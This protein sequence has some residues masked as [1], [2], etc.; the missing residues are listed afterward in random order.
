MRIKITSG[1]ASAIAGTFLLLAGTPSTTMAAGGYEGLESSGI[2]VHDLASVQRGAGLFFNYCH[3]CHSA[4]YMRYQRLAQDLELPEEMVQNNLV[5]G[6]RE[7]TDYMKAAIPAENATSWFGKKPPDLTLK[8]RSRGPDWIYT[9][10][11][12]YYMTDEG[13]NN[14]ILENASMPNVLWELQGIQRPIFETH[15]DETGATHSELVEL[16]LDQPGLQSPEEFERTVRD[17]TAFMEYLAEPAVLKRERMGIWVLLF[18]VAFTFMSWLL[19][20]E[21]WK[22]VKK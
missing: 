13:W 8:A 10:L 7:I 19:Y 21:Y 18:M 16:R 9:F 14:K 5:F 3:S 2:N 15:T 17:I 1:I 20:H 22:D 11:K 6:D 4:E 12:S